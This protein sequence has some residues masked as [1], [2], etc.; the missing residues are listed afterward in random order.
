MT[1]VFGYETESS[2]YSTLTMT[3]KRRNSAQGQRS[4]TKKAKS[5]VQQGQP[6]NQVVN[7]AQPQ[8]SPQEDHHPWESAIKHLRE[9]NLNA[10][11]RTDGD[12]RDRVELQPYT[13]AENVKLEVFLLRHEHNLLGGLKNLLAYVDGSVLIYE[14]DISEAHDVLADWFSIVWVGANANIRRR[15]QGTA[16]FDLTIAPN[17]VQQADRS[18]RPRNRTGMPANTDGARFPTIVI[19]V[20]VSSSL[21]SLHTKAQRYLG[22]GTDVQIVLC[23]S[24]WPRRDNNLHNFQ[25]VAL[26]YLRDHSVMLPQ[27]VVSFGSAALHWETLNSIQSFFEDEWN[28]RRPIPGPD[29]APIVPPAAPAQLP[30]FPPA[31]FV[32]PI[33]GHLN[34]ATVPPGV[35]P[36]PVYI[37][38]PVCSMGSLE[39]SLLQVGKC[40]CQQSTKLKI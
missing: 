25:M 38:Q 33:H 30:E 36:N 9:T 39:W 18:F 4:K 6:V 10:H 3:A 37:L 34:A 23:I 2:S 16:G 7:N 11:R 1:S 20:G 24:V 12:E 31:G 29:G 40:F 17:L 8:D 27:L 19:E 21:A 13:I 15:L 26:L 28:A 35:P 22:G 14:L 32:Y 5:T